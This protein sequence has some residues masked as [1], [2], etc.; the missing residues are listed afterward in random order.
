LGIFLFTTAS[1]MAL[2]PTQPPI[3][4]IPGALSLRVKQLGHEADHQPPSSAE[5]KYVWSYTSITPT[6]LHGMVLSQAQGQLY[7]TFT[8]L[9]QFLPPPHL[10]IV[11]LSS[12]LLTTTILSLL[13]MNLLFISFTHPFQ[14][15]VLDG[16]W[17][18]T[19]DF[20]S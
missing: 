5:V 13:C 9:S 19:T 15:N 7:L 6:H 20:T 14:V 4:C 10:S 16:C 1:R 12:H 18:N 11:M 3:Q 17:V 2:G 8:L